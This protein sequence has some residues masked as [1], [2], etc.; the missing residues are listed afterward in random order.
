MPKAAFLA[1]LRHFLT[2]AG[3]ALLATS[4]LSPDDIETLAGAAVAV[5]GVAWSL[6]DKR[7]HRGEPK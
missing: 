4:D 2:V 1:L 5:L 3:G 7:R 6:Y